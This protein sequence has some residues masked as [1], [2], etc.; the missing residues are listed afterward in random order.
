[1]LMIGVQRVLTVAA[2]SVR[3]RVSLKEVMHDEGC[4][5]RSRLEEKAVD[6]RMAMG[7]GVEF[8]EMV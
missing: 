1:M 3:F 6:A 5:W 7:E 8:Q 2:L 4:S